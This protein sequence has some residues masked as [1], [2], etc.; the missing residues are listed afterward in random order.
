MAHRAAAASFVASASGA[1]GSPARAARSALGS[2]EARIEP[3]DLIG[4]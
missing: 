3:E 2:D 4:G 1:A